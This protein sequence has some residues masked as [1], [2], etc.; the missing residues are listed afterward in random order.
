VPPNDRG[1]LDDDE[2]FL[3][4]RPEPEQH[5]PKRTIQRSEPR[6]RLPLSVGRELLAQCKFNDRLLAAASEEG[7]SAAKK[8][9]HEIEQNPHGVR[10]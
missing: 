5:D 2:R 9:G 3:P 4:A 8:S 6:L 10:L 7:E 1:W